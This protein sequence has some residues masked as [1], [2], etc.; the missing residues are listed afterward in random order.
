MPRC[1]S[2][3]S[4]RPR[5]RSASRMSR[6][7]STAPPSR[8]RAC[9]PHGSHALGRLR[10]S[11]RRLDHSR[12][13]HRGCGRSRM[14]FARRQPMTFFG[15]L[16]AGFALAAFSRAPPIAATR[17]PRRRWRVRRVRR[18]R[19]LTRKA[20]KIRVR[21]IERRLRGRSGSCRDGGRKQE[22]LTWPRLRPRHARARDRRGARA[23]CRDAGSLEQPR[24]GDRGQAG[25]DGLR[26][27][28]RQ[29]LEYVQQTKDSVLEAGQGREP[30]RSAQAEGLGESAWRGADRRRHR[31]ALLQAS[32]DH[33][34]ARRGRHCGL[35]QG[36]ARRQAAMVGSPIVLPTTAIGRAATFPA[37]SPDTAIRH[38]EDGGPGIGEQVKAAASHRRA[39]AR[40][41]R[42][43]A[44]HGA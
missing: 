11:R 22:Q 37:A 32:T 35:G 19:R 8:S 13:K 17:K 7:R 9:C 16:L 30:R 14:D 24:D 26:A 21:R 12:S 4:R 40:G 38:R 44:R 1:K 36:Q 10:H 20:Q 2:S 31:M 27:G 23:P 29:A 18:T 34:A 6:A 5:P 25:A 33:E 28:P 3:S 15:S 42:K 41:N 39:G 43:G